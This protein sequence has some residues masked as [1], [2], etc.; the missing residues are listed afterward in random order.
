MILSILFDIWLLTKIV[1]FLLPAIAIIDIIRR[2]LLGLNKLFWIALVVIIPF[3]GS[4]IYFY[5]R[6]TY[7]NR[8]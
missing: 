8:N 1:A 4:I 7:K 6:F 5:D 3:V 2:D